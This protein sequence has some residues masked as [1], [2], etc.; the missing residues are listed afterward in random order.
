RK[1]CRGALRI[2][3]KTLKLLVVR[4][5]SGLNGRFSRP[6]GNRATTNKGNGLHRTEE[7]DECVHIPEGGM[8]ERPGQAAGGYKAETLP[9]PDRPLIGGD[10]KVELHGAEPPLSGACDR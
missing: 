3:I 7:H 6:R 9:N 2:A 4:Q 1:R 5:F 8:E 10:H